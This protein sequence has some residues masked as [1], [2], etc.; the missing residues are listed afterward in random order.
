MKKTYH[1]IVQG[2]CLNVMKSLKENSI[3]FICADFPYNISNNPGLTMKWNKIVKSD[4]GEWD[5][6]DSH[7]EY[8]EFV[9][10][11]CKEYQRI[12]KP[13][14]NMILFF[15]Y[16][17]SWWLAYELEKRGL[18]TYRM[19]IIFNKM[20]P[21]PHFREN[22]FR[23]CHE[24]GVWLVNGG[25]K[26]NKPRTFNFLGQSKMKNV[27]NYKIGRDGNKQTNHP[28]EK[29]EFLIGGL[30][31][32]FTKPWEVVL[33]N[34]AWGWTTGV[35]A[36]KKWRHCISIEKEFE[37]IKTIKKRQIRAEKNRGS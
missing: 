4:F 5:K 23:S 7:E 2:D 12:L 16:H 11:I 19:P 26:F 33:D 15:S 18:F 37:F 25:W 36:Y 1:K 29:P 8:I 35:A 28:T 6:W 31:E 24:V 22:G 13:N 10:K 3:D 9:F 21:L 17:Y 30:I 34:F 20:N 27:L 32:V 14:G